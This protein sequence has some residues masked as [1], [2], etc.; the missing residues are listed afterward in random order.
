MAIKPGDLRR[1]TLLGVA[2]S[3]AVGCRTNRSG[4]NWRFFTE[5]Q[6]RTVEAITAQLIP[7]DQ[8]PGAKEA[9]AVYYIDM[10]LSRRFRKHQKAY[11]EGLVKV[12]EISRKTG[13]KRF[14]ELTSDQQVEALNTLE[15]TAK[16]FFGL[17]LAHTRQ[18]FYGDP[19]HGGNRNMVS[20]KMVGLP[21][22]QIRGR[23][24]YDASNTG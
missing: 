8:D 12:D 15:E 17:I 24:Q 10:Q 5:D 13:G 9:G 1:R 6:G 16:P 11:R 7:A 3:A 22:P 18:G 20:W 14:L 23:Q 2:V 19:R 4:H 21:F